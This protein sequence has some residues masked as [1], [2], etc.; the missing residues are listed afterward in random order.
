[1]KPLALLAAGA[2][3][4]AGLAQPDPT[5]RIVRPLDPA[6]IPS[7]TKMPSPALLPVPAQPKPT[8]VEPTPARA[9]SENASVPTLRPDA[10][11]TQKKD[12]SLEDVG[13]TLGED[14]ALIP[15]ASPPVLPPT[16][17]A[18]LERPKI[19]DVKDHP[20]I[21]EPFGAP[22][23]DQAGRPASNLFIVNTLRLNVRIGASAKTEK[24]G[25]LAAG[26]QVMAADSLYGNEVKGWIEISARGGAIR[27]WVKKSLLLTT[28]TP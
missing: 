21:G 27:G 6:T 15:S 26:E 16:P 5:R 7:S 20:E 4:V 23:S 8:V 10:P 17:Q 22:S 11:F 14:H 18:S 13:D 3:V 28:E 1:M 12:A 24:V 19:I 9:P 2:L 25:E